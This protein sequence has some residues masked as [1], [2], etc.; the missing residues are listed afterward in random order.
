MMES[1]AEGKVFSEMRVLECC[2][3]RGDGRLLWGGTAG[4]HL[5]RLPQLRKGPLP[6]QTVALHLST[7]LYT[8]SELMYSYSGI[9]GKR[10]ASPC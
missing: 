4:P 1:Q 9:R 8:T 3:Q 2:G 7:Q 6:L 10:P 5:A